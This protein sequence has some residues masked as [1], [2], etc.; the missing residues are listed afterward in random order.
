[1]IN[2]S[3]VQH[4]QLQES[5]TSKCGASA[6]FQNLSKKHLM[7]VVGSFGIIG[8]M[9]KSSMSIEEMDSDDVYE[10]TLNFGK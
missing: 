7:E 8:E 3:L 5:G 9:W 2:D 10:Y 4:C 6:I 1:M